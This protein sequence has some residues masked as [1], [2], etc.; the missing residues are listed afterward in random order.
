MLI[1]NYDREITGN[2]NLQAT[3]IPHLLFQENPKFP[4]ESI[5]PLQL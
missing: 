2:Q 1:F 5:P 3:N 4:N